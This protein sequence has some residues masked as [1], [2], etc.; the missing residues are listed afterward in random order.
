MSE[1]EN[2][3]TPENTNQQA[4]KP[5]DV[6]SLKQ[7]DMTVD[8]YNQY[9]DLEPDDPQVAD[10]LGRYGIIPGESIIVSA[11]D[12]EHPENNIL[13]VVATGEDSFT[14]NRLLT[15]ELES[16]LRDSDERAEHMATNDSIH[17]LGS[18]ALDATASITASHEKEP[19]KETSFNLELIEG[20]IGGLYSVTE[21]FRQSPEAEGRH[22]MN[23]YITRE[24]TTAYDAFKSGKI[25]E[26]SYSV[27][28]N[29]LLGA[30]SSYMSIEAVVDTLMDAKVLD[31]D[32]KVD[33]LAH[34]RSISEIAALPGLDGERARISYANSLITQS[35]NL[36][37]KNNYVASG[38]YK[39]TV[40][41]IAGLSTQI[42]DYNTSSGFVHGALG[43]LKQ[44]S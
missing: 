5:I 20:A 43:R 35:E 26:E 17:E 11:T 29:T 38:R 44:Y 22:Y 1:Q 6:M 16:R 7:I 4:E 3:N 12:S 42:K 8:D 32:T 23:G 33:L 2:Y 39:A 14:T 24:A 30:A 19:S 21:N 28:A 9:S 37:E 15:N 40:G 18:H 31:A 41:F 27:L 13:R 25:S 34:A 10:L 36:L